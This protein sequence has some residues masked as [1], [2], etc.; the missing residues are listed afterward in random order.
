MWALI[1]ILFIE[2]AE[3]GIDGEGTILRGA[4]HG[5]IIAFFGAF[6]SCSIKKKKQRHTVK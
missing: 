5:G 3:E 2:E 4:G 1:L 6:L